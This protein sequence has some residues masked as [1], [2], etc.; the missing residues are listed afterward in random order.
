MSLLEKEMSLLRNYVKT[1]KSKH[2]KSRRNP[3]SIHN[4]NSK[5]IIKAAV[6]LPKKD[7]YKN[8]N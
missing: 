2:F 7:K 5:K 4:I 6:P 1:K 3:Y 8:H